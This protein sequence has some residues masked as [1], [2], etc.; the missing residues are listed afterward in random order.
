VLR[1]LIIREFVK[2]NAIALKPGLVKGPLIKGLGFGE[3]VLLRICW[4]S[5][6]DRSVL[7]KLPLYRGAWA[8]Y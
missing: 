2:A 3:V 5:N 4:S 1:D 6:P 7:R 8:G